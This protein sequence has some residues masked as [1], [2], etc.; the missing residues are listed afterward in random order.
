MRPARP[1]DERG[2]TLIEL[3]IAASL[4]VVI[5]SIGTPQYV[6]A[7]RNARVCRARQE[8]QLIAKSIDTYATRN[9]QLPLSLHQVGYGGRVDPWGLPY[10]YLNCGTGTGD[11][12]DWAIAA[13][14]IDPSAVVS[15]PTSTSESGGTVP[16]RLGGARP[17]GQ[18]GGA[19]ASAAQGAQG[20]R[21]E[22]PTQSTL[23]GT[24]ISAAL[25]TEAAATAATAI[26]AGASRRVAAS[27]VEALMASLAAGAGRYEVFTGVS[28]PSTRR[29]D[30]FM[31]PLNTDYDLFSLGPDKAT[32]LALQSRSGIDDVIRA[33][34][35]AFFGIAGE[36]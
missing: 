36:Y 5:A 24:E 12:L 23:S 29:R 31:F 30:G 27:E 14:V 1:T 16:R 34:N 21:T 19:G 22:P 9:G 11:G 25:R 8:L 33:N 20:S 2:F 17:Q 18:G 28:V 3:M 26:A 13:G 35:G 10:C 6:A 15:S 4:L 7:L 32:A